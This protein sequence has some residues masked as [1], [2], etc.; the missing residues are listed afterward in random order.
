LDTVHAL[1]KL[2]A[3]SIEADRPLLGGAPAAGERVST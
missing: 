1:T 3:K 2:L